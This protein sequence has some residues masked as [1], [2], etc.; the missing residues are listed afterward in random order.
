MKKNLLIVLVM[1]LAINLFGK[2]TETKKTIVDL[3][4]FG[5]YN[6]TTTEKF[7]GLLKRVE[8]NSDLEGKGIWGK[9]LSNFFPKGNN[10]TIYDLNEKFIY[11]MN[12]DKETYVKSPIE[13]YFEEDFLEEDEESEA[14]ESQEDIEEEPTFKIIRQEFKIIDTKEFIEFNQFNAH[15][16]IIHYLLEKI[17]IETKK[18]YTDSL[19]VE[20]FT[21]N[22]N[23]L[24]ERS[25]NEKEEFNLAMLEAIGL[26]LD[27]E[28][29]QS[30][31]G[32]QWIKKLEAMDSESQT[33][34][35]DI[36]YKE[37]EKMEGHPVLIDGSYYVKKV[38]PKPVE[39]KKKGFGGLSGLKK[40]LMKKAENAVTKK[41]KAVYKKIIAYKTETISIDFDQ[42]TDADFVVPSNFTEK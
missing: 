31:L 6:S 37:F 24:F 38:E 26:E 32:I 25:A 19:Y 42:A 7:D 5:I 39:K 28:D 20:L 22:E 34:E 3:P 9:L 30:I 14:E 8:S 18:V 41:D 35:F 29:Y 36:D 13:K 27:K 4:K 40:N 21:S 11:A 1:I 15:K 16:Y 12:L 33:S 23:K 2:L 10:A 17:E